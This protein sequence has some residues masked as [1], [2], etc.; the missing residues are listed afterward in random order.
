MTKSFILLLF[1][2][3]LTACGGEST[4]KKQTKKQPPAA[5]KTANKKTDERGFDPCLLNANLAVCKNNE[6]VNS[7]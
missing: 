1:A 3:S 7:K 2:F 5:E 6:T 4:I